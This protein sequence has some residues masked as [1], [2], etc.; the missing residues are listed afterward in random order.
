MCLVSG[1]VCQNWFWLAHPESNLL[2]FLINE[3]YE[4]IA[5]PLSKMPNFIE[6]IL[7]TTKKM[8]NNFVTCF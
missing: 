7:N 1:K 6:K 5:A 2:F 4:I 8:Q 3:L